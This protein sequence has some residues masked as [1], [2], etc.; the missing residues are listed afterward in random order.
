VTSLRV[1]VILTI[2]VFVFLCIGLVAGL[3]QDQATARVSFSSE[4]LPAGHPVTGAIYFSSTS[5]DPLAINAVSIHFD[6]MPSG[7]VVGYQ[8][9]TPVTIEGGGNHLFDPMQIQIPLNI[10]SGSHTYYIG[11][12]GTENGV[13]FSWDS[14]IAS[15]DVISGT[16]N[17]TTSPS[18]T[19]SGGEQPEGQPNL[20]LYG[21]IAGV[22]VIVVLLLIVF[23]MRKKRTGSKLAVNQEAGSQPKPLNPEK[24]PNPEQ[25]FNI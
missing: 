11:I 23:I 7:Q 5:S 8:L 22:V 10:A 21:A 3:N 15:V 25:D 20:L 1:S 12:D 9:T 19:N 2:L 17:V 4:T 6:W 14:P 18:S 13:P 16:G 24:K